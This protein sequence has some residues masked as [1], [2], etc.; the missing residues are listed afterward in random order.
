MRY[1]FAIICMLFS[2]GHASAA[3]VQEIVSDK[4]I[5]A[6][7]VEEKS[8]PLFAVKITFTGAG[9]AYDPAGKEGRANRV[10]A[11]LTEGAGDLD[12]RAFSVAVESHAIGLQMGAEEDRFNVSLESLSEHKDKAFE[13]LGLVLTK[14]RFDR[15]SLERVKNQTLSIIKQQ[16]SR[17][18]YQLQMAMARA[19]FGDH[20]YSRPPLGTLASADNISRSDLTDYTERYLTRGNLVIAIVG[21]LSA[22][23]AKRLLDT[24]LGNL[25]ERYDPE[26][27]LDEVTLPTPGKQVHVDFN[28]PQTMVAFAMQ[29]IKR[30]DPDYMVAHVMNHILG[31]GG[32]LNARLGREIREK[33]GLSYSVFSGLD[34]MDHAALLRGGFATKNEQ[35]PEAIKTLKDT[36]ADFSANGPTDVEFADAKEFIKGSFVLSLDSN[37]EIASFL[38]NMQLHAL[39][40]D[41]LEKRN[42][43]VEAVTREQVA[44]MAKRL[45]I[46]DNLL[47]I[48]VGKKP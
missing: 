8:L 12:S 30:T 41:Y 42:Q 9:S 24:H 16:E 38:I 13:L 15:D 14:P 2:A 37:A 5:K 43:L 34:P 3:E 20:P 25:P 1:F 45:I 22:D 19:A 27:K 33:R 4:G 44:A 17:P 10:A 7:L 39:G 26:T 28:V 46:P 29:G 48:S 18:G 35:A 32:S 36:L 21:D 23:E 11:L 40:I 47:V 6:W 31:G